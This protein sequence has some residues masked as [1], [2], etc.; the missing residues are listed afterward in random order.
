MVLR[1][2]HCAYG[3]NARPV[4][5][6]DEMRARAET[7]NVPRLVQG[8]DGA[9]WVADV[10][11]DPMRTLPGGAGYLIVQYYEARLAERRVTE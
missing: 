7:A 3:V 1:H 6:G 5:D 2:S 8:S 10:K 9:G 4:S 11:K